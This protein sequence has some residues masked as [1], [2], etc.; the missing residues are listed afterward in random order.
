MYVQIKDDNVDL[1][2]YMFP[3][4]EI[5]PEEQLRL[6][7]AIDLK[8]STLK[9]EFLEPRHF[10]EYSSHIQFR[11]FQP[12][13]KMQLH[14]QIREGAFHNVLKSIMNVNKLHNTFSSVDKF[15]REE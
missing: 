8:Q 11:R 15:I 7:L 5:A 4:K 3:K 14:Q 1:I 12:Q 2:K 10:Q 6:L 9:M 13:D